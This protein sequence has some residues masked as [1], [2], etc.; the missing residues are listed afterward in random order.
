MDVKLSD[1]I[2]AAVNRQVKDMRGGAAPASDAPD[3]KSIQPVRERNLRY[4]IEIEMLPKS[5][6]LRV[7]NESLAALSAKGE[8]NNSRKPFLSLEKD[9][10]H[11]RMEGQSHPS[12][13][14]RYLDHTILSLPHYPPHYPHLAAMRRELESWLFFYFEPRER[15]RSINPVK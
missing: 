5:G 12:Y 15:M 4:R 10:L 14:D 7:A 11:L 8:P 6:I 2:I 13:H 1:T 3:G 9:K